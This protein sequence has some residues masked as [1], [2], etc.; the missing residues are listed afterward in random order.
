[1][2]DPLSHYMTDPEMVAVTGYDP[3]PITRTVSLTFYPGIRPLTLS[4]PAGDVRATP[5]LM[6]SRDSYTR[7]VCSRPRAAQHRATLELAGRMPP[8]AAGARTRVLGVA[9]EGTLAAGAPPIARRGDRRRRL[10]QQLVL[11]LHV[12]S[13]L[14]LAAVRWL[15]REE[16]TTAV[17]TRIPVPP[18]VLLTEAQSRVIFTSSSSCCRLTVI[19]LGGLVWWRRR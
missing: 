16:R 2:V 6:S 19:A 11:S 18:L 15:A 17:R 9:A 3:H 7:D 14:L 10:R 1:M 13:D 5:L 12:N 8:R 4:E